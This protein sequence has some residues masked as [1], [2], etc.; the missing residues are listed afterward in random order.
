M[1]ICY[2]HAS[3]PALVEGDPCV[4]PR[5]V[6]HG[7]L[8]GR[9]VGAFLLVG[10]KE[11]AMRARRRRLRRANLTCRVKPRQVGSSISPFSRGRRVLPQGEHLCA[12]ECR[13]SRLAVWGFAT[14][15]SCEQSV[16]A[17]CLRRTDG[18]VIDASIGATSAAQLIARGIN[19]RARGINARADLSRNTFHTTPPD[20]T[21]KYPCL[22]RVGLPI[23]LVEMKSRYLNYVS[24][25]MHALCWVDCDETWGLAEAC[26]LARHRC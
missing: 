3:V 25:R 6:A 5:Q 11:H 19:A 9:H 8:P 23:W 26:W 12:D 2:G 15:P 4:L 14:K 10:V 18:W 17:H 24:D 20:K 22:M 16:C 21:K 13:T 1:D 7:Q